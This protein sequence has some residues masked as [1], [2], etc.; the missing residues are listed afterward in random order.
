MK[1]WACLYPEEMQHIIC[2]GADVM[3]RAAIQVMARQ[4]RCVMLPLPEASEGSE[5][6]GEEVMSM[7]HKSS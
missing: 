6:G 2:T 5:G 1:Y 4:A 3:L 7:E